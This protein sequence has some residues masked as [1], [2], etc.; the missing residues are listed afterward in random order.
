M[1]R[2]GDMK[3]SLEVDYKHN[4]NVLQITFTREHLEACRTDTTK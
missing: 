4:K 2:N 3:L 1:S